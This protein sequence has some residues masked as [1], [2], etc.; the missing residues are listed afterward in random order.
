MDTSEDIL[1]EQ[2]EEAQDAMFVDIVQNYADSVALLS[3]A[4]TQRYQGKA[5]LF[6]ADKTVPEKMNIQAAWAPY[7]DELEEHHFDF[8]HE[9]ILSPEALTALGPVFNQLVSEL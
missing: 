5:V 9:D 4:K 3:K 1:D 6:V 8:A 2:V 7:V